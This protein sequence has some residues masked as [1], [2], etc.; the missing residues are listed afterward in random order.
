[1]ADSHIIK[2]P[3]QTYQPYD[4]TDEG[5]VDTAPTNHDVYAGNGGSGD[6]GG[7]VKIKDAGA[8]SWSDGSVT[9]DWP[10]DGTSDGSAWKQC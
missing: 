4:A 2:A 5:T 6:T 3:A 7:W 9:G 8:A 1:M 10:S